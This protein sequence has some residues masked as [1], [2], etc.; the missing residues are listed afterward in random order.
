MF[1]A[2]KKFAIF[3]EHRERYEELLAEF[4]AKAR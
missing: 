1:K 2:T 3:P 4:Q